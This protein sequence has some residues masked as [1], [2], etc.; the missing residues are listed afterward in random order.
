M[1]LLINLIFLNEILKF[2]KNEPNNYSFYSIFKYY[3]ESR[4]YISLFK[5]FIKIIINPKFFL[6]I[7]DFFGFGMYYRKKITLKD[8]VNNVR[9]SSKKNLTINELNSKYFYKKV[10]YFSNSYQIIAKKNYN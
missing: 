4:G 10:S 2:K 3:I 9:K 6:I 5:F 7:K 8:I 1:F